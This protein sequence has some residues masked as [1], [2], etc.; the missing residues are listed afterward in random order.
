MLKKTFYIIL[1]I[2]ISGTSAIIS[3][4]YLFPRL[5]AT[6]LFSKY[7]FLKKSAENVTVINKTEQVY[8]K[9]D[10]SINKIVSQVTPAIVNIVSYS[11]DGANFR[12]G[13]GEIVTSDGIIM[14]YA[15]AIILS[16]SLKT[17]SLAGKYKIM[18]ADGQIYDGELLGVDSWS[19][20]AFIKIHASNLPV[21]SFGNSEDY[22]P[23]EKIIAI[24]N[25][26]T[27][28]QNRFNAGVLG[29]F[30]PSYNISGQT[31]SISEKLEGVYLTDFNAERLSVGG[32]IVDYSGRV[33]GITGSTIRN[34]KVEYFEIPC[35]KVKK[36][37]EKVINKN[38]NTN[39]VLGV[40]YVS[41]NKSYALAHNLSLEKGAMIFSPSGQNGLAIIAGSPAAK[42]ELEIND[43]ITHIDGEEITLNN[44]LSTILYKYK[45]GDAAELT[46]V[47]E[48]KETKM[49]V[50]F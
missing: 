13:T 14:T 24:G 38:L 30:N 2:L 7:E 49:R 50:Q 31:L 33:V 48:G 32:P 16:G 25:D 46:V 22:R 3:D 5:A 36:I 42:S 39:P 29:G 9:E 44:N 11:S 27:E 21:I 15:D 1:I 35:D 34:N 43:V 26:T 40:Y 45:K 6:K 37:L 47:R 4:R 17:Q 12:N 41:L 23:G 10:S 8:V 18:T 28:Y 20:L 19:N